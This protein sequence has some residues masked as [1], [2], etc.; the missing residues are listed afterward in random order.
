[1][2][3]DSQNP[4]KTPG[5]RA[6]GQSLCWDGRGKR[7]PGACFSASQHICT[8]QIERENLSL[9]LGQR[10]MKRDLWPVPIFHMCTNIPEHIHKSYVQ[11]SM[12]NCTS[13][14]K[15]TFWQHRIFSIWFLLF[16]NR[17]HNTPFQS[18]WLEWSHHLRAEHNLVTLY[19]TPL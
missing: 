8:F 6:N 1:M 4:S 5:N 12:W 11:S 7:I 14:K 16:E 18:W 13:I 10:V 2:S 19:Y 9:K 3:S 17:P 15:T